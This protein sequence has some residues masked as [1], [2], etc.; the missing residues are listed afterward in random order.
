M[1]YSKQYIVSNRTMLLTSVSL[2]LFLSPRIVY[3]NVLRYTSYTYVKR[4]LCLPRDYTYTRATER[5]MIRER[6]RRKRRKML[7]QLVAISART[8]SCK[9]YTYRIALPLTLY[10]RMHERRIGLR[11]ASQSKLRASGHGEF[12][13]TL[14]LNFSI[15][16][17]APKSERSLINRCRYVKSFSMIG[18]S[19]FN[20]QS[21]LYD[22]WKNYRCDWIY[23]GTFLLLLLAPLM[24]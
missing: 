9:A 23:N 16:L 5:S 10:I 18:F 7:P 11:V 6:R 14:A 22:F 12:S 19:L 24:K 8:E 17:S 15:P 1:T 13:C 4:A 2:S 20:I 21:Y 3:L